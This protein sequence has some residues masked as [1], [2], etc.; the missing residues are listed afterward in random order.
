M[1]LSLTFSFNGTAQVN[2]QAIGLRGG[3]GNLGYG[4]EITYQHGFGEANR[5]ELDF[6]WINNRYN[7][8]NY[9]V[10]GISAI[11]HWVWNITDGLNWYVGPGAQLGFYQDRNDAALDGISIGLLGQ[12]GIEYDFNQHGVPLLLSLDARPRF[13]FIGGTDGPGYG[14]AFA[15]RYTF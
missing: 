5:L 13:G 3:S 1:L 10:L 9:S 2:P 12:I 14:S 8:N 7:K 6:G 4:G 15:L 11:Y